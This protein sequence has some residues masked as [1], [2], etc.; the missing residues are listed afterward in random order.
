MEKNNK[1]L[2]NEIKFNKI[3]II[4]LIVVFI[5]SLIFNFKFIIDEKKFNTAEYFI[6][7]YNEQFEKQFG[8]EI[9]GEKVIQLLN[10]VIFNNNNSSVNR[11]GIDPCY[12]T[13]NGKMMTG[14]NNYKPNYIENKIKPTIIKDKKYIVRATSVSIAYSELGFIQRI[15]IADKSEL[16]DEEVNQFNNS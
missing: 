16:Q 14:Q 8:K 7:E 3:V 15:C 5:G 1:E 12:T 4:L 10:D 11:I 9:S 2:V 6:K 13:Q